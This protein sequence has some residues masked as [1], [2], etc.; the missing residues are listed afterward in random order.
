MSANGIT[1]TL[2]RALL[3]GGA[4]WALE[5]LF[6]SGPKR[7]SALWKGVKVPVL[8]VYAVGG[9]LAASLSSTLRERGLPWYARAAAYG[10]LL[11]GVEYAGCAIDRDVLGACSWD[12]ASSG[13]KEPMQGCVDFKHAAL[14]GMLG[15]LVEKI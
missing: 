7:Y 14:W 8:P 11:S 13:C 12:Y 4:G 3:F 1:Q 5:N 15:L 9:T 6:A 2:E 10:A